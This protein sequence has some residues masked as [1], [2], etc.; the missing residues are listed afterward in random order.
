[1]MNVRVVVARANGDF[2]GVEWMNV[3]SEELA[4]QMTHLEEGDWVVVATE[5]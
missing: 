3:R 1:M 5:F 2:E 4:V